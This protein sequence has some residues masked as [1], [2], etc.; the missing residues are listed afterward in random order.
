MAT[1]IK[2]T[3]P[4][5]A[6]GGFIPR[7]YTCQGDDINPPL[8][9]QGIPPRAK[10]LALVVDDPDAPGGVWT[11]WLVWNIN[12][13]ATSLGENAIPLRATLGKNSFQKLEYGGPCPPSGTHRYFFKLYALEKNLNLAQG[14]SRQQLETAMKGHI[15]SS[16]FLMGRYKK[17]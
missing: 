9:W 1:T 17:E 13:Q 5:F 7:K 2:I 3:S 8:R 4:V 11:H 10:S 16:G 6:D 15:L 14:A 12:P